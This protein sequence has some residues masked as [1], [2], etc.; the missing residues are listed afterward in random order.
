MAPFKRHTAQTALVAL[1]VV[2]LL[3][4]AVAL[5]RQ[6]KAQYDKFLGGYWI[7]TPDFAERAN[8]SEFQLF[9]SPPEAPAAVF[10]APARQGYLIVIDA[11]GKTLASQALELRAA[12]AFGAGASALLADEFRGRLRLVSEEP[13]DALPET[14]QFSVSALNGTLTLFDGES[15][16]ANLAKEFA[17]S[18]AALAAFDAPADAPDEL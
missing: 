18:S 1:L 17:T 13:L 3:V 4:A 9:I 15:V 8:L 11:N 6:K 2:L 5:C 16:Y 10:G 14:L 12:P 7:A